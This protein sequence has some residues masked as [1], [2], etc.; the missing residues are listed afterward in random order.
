M[1]LHTGAKNANYQLELLLMMDSLAISH[2]M[3]L[4]D[5][6]S[7]RKHSINGNLLL[8]ALVVDILLLS[9][10]AKPTLPH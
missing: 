7:V 9:T 6:N 5:L 4:S 2:K 3:Q 8:L 1:A 10:V